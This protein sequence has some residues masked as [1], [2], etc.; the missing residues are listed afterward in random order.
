VA[1]VT[2]LQSYPVTRTAQGDFR[3]A[4]GDLYATSPRSLGLVFH[5][6]D[7]GTLGETRI[8]EVRVSADVIQQDGIAH[9]KLVLPVVA[10]LD[11]ADH[12]EPTVE[13]TF[14]RFETAKAREEAVRRAD[15]GDL[16][17][18]AQSLQQAYSLLKPYQAEPG[19]QEE[20]ED[21]TAEAQRLQD[22]HYDAA[23]RKYHSARAMAMRDEKAAYLKKMR[24]PRPKAQP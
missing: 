7:V 24:R 22:R 2:F 19:V 17:G 23:D 10:N 13:R 20:I 18:A 4:L 14:V 11:G 8:A 5:V 3:I 15:A 16:G 1:G 12:V 21:L 6:N 9:E